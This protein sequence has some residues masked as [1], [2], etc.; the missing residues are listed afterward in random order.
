MAVHVCYV[1]VPSWDYVINQSAS[2]RF[3]SLRV[4]QKCMSVTYI[5]PRCA[6]AINGL[7]TTIAAVQKYRLPAQSS[8]YFYVRLHPSQISHLL[9]T[10]GH[11]RGIEPPHALNLTPA[12]HPSYPTHPCRPS[13]PCRHQ[14]NSR[15]LPYRS[16]IHNLP[17][18]TQSGCSTW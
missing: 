2:R 15:H 7:K 3:E 18:Y 11:S 1:T 10:W 5:R 4:L 13:Q 12:L 8:S 9:Q 16:R 17:R 14:P 6:N